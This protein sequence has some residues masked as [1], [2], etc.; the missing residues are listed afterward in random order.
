MKPDPG[1]EL[2]AYEAGE[3][4]GVTRQAI[5]K[6]IK[7]GHLPARVVQQGRFQYVL[8]RRGDLDRYVQNRRHRRRLLMPE[9]YVSSLPDS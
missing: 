3:V 7:Q 1:Q 5:H 8:V 2:T 9:G 4:I 6:I